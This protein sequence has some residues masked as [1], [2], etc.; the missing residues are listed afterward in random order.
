MNS[1]A[2]TE[3]TVRAERVAHGIVVEVEDRGLGM[4]DEDMALANEHLASPPEFDLADSDKLGFFVM[5]RLAARHSIKITLRMS[6]YGGVSAIVLLPHAVTVTPD[7]TDTDLI[8]AYPDPLG[9]PA[10]GWEPAVAVPDARLAAGQDE[11]PS[12]PRGFGGDPLD[13]DTVG[14]PRRVRYDEQVT[15]P[16]RP[17]RPAPAARSTPE[18]IG[19]LVTSLQQGWLGGRNQAS[20][21]DDT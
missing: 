7:T 2:S 19:A 4:T 1:P 5:S 20:Q 8:S 6:P 11:L 3:V 15:P 12:E 13:E 21:S 14:L 18:E 10:A 16:A 9:L 17:A